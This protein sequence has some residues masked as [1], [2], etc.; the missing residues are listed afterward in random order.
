M[1]TQ[2]SGFQLKAVCTPQP[3]SKKYKERSSLW[4][5]KYYISRVCNKDNSASSHRHALKEISRVAAESFTLKTVKYWTNLLVKTW[6]FTIMSWKKK[7]ELKKIRSEHCLMSHDICH[8]LKPRRFLTLIN[9]WFC[10]IKSLTSF[11]WKLS[12][13]SMLHCWKLTILL[14][15]QKWRKWNLKYYSH[16]NF[17]F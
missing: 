11:T 1:L 9:T 6:I 14:L 8:Y 13:T 12:V 15:S 16:W 10:N 3:D 4:H 5:A 7:K 17:W 2:V